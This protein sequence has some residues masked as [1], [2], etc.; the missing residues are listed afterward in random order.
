MHTRKFT[1]QLLAGSVQL[2]HFNEQ[3]F[4]KLLE[5]TTL[6]R[7]DKHINKHQFSR[8]YQDQNKALF[9]EFYFGGAIKV[10]TTEDLD[11]IKSVNFQQMPTW[12]F[13]DQITYSL[14]LSEADY[15]LMIQTAKPYTFEQQ[16]IQTY[17]ISAYQKTDGSLLSE[18]KDACSFAGYH[19]YEHTDA[20]IISDFELPNILYNDRKSD[21]SYQ[22]L[23]KKTWTPFNIHIQEGKSTNTEEA[24]MLLSK[25]YNIDLELL[26]YTTESLKVLEHPIMQNWNRVKSEEVCLPFIAY[27][28][29]MIVRNHALKWAI[30]DGIPALVH[31]K[32]SDFDIY[33][34]VFREMF[35][36][37]SLVGSALDTYQSIEHEINEL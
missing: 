35:S 28:G 29:E 32:G 18:A 34:Q 1:L 21:E 30:I 15:E 19:L 3:A 12:C 14:S 23:Y 9:L 10:M 17:I 4:A 20:L 5:Q 7:V 11:K 16:I 26:D 6:S 33:T 31:H 25:V 24:R 27:I 8:I 22:P 13:G 36:Y 37:G 2:T